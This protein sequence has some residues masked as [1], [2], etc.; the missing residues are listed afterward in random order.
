MSTPVVDKV[1]EQ[2]RDLPY[3]LQW[4]VL[5]FTRALAVSVPHGVPGQQL[6]EFAGSIPPDDLQVMRQA[7]QDGCEQVDANEW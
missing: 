5:E 4:R 2:L 1:V 3:E 7:I 6:L